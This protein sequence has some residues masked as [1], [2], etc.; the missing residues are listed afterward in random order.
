MRTAEVAWP[1]SANSSASSR[2]L[3]KI[4]RLN[5]NRIA[6]KWLA[7]SSGTGID[8]IDDLSSSLIESTARIL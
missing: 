2:K 3:P 1:S 4:S 7:A 6:P 5:A 8:A